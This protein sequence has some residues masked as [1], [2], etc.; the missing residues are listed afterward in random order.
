MSALLAKRLA[1]NHT[2]TTE[3][4]SNRDANKRL[5]TQCVNSLSRDQE[6]SSQQVVSYIMRWNDCYLSH[7]YVAIHWSG[8]IAELRKCFPLINN[9]VNLH[10]SSNDHSDPDTIL[11]IVGNNLEL[12]S[13]VDDY[14]NRGLQLERYSLFQFLLDSYEPRKSVKKTG[15]TSNSRIPYIDGVE[16]Y[17]DRFRVLRMP[18]HEMMPDFLVQWLPRRDD[19]TV[20]N[21]Y[22]APR[23]HVGNILGSL[24][25]NTSQ[26][27]KNLLDNFQFYYACEH[28][29]G[30]KKG[31]DETRYNPENV[32]PDLLDSV[33]NSSKNNEETAYNIEQMAEDVI[34]TREILYGRQAVDIGVHTGI[35]SDSDHWTV[36]HIDVTY[37]ESALLE[38]NLEWQKVIKE[39]SQ[40]ENDQ[41][42]SPPV[43]PIVSAYPGNVQPPSIRLSLMTDYGQQPMNAT[44]P[45]GLSNLSSQQ[46][47]A[48]GIIDNHL[49]QNLQ[50]KIRSNS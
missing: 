50:G 33:E 37:P 32:F 5:I 2:D 10:P 7:S 16:A 45:D 1:Y 19:P 39:Y 6:L 38:R 22:C 24:L 28:S 40:L 12:K 25:S 4:T 13:Q 36:E 18:G 41:H 20:R 35:F 34:P 49:E 23:L 44:Y 14:K 46:R 29:A 15:K 43:W 30:K 9:T 27:T 3:S 48:F 21:L 17:K 11:H 42:L 26:S 31:C 47:R 8:A